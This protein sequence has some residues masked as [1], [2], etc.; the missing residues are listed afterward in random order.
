MLKVKNLFN[1]IYLGF[2]FLKEEMFDIEVYG[3]KPKMFRK[4]FNRVILRI[5]VF[6][7]PKVF[8]EFRFA[9]I[10]FEKLDFRARIF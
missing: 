4:K 1:I 3:E 8:A 5:S 10:T 9:E 2:D 7:R 6:A